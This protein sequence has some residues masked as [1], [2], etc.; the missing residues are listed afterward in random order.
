[1]LVVA[2]T[3]ASAVDWTTAVRDPYSL[4]ND[5][6]PGFAVLQELYEFVRPHR[7]TEQKTLNALARCR[8]EK[9]K[10]IEILNAFSDHFDMQI[11]GQTYDGRLGFKQDIKRCSYF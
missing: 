5:A 7:F 1:M 3:G 11:A 6:P 10:L 9:A 2:F 4:V 8:P